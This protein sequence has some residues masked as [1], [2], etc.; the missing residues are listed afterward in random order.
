M[1]V[2]SGIRRLQFLQ[3]QLVGSLCHHPFA[4]F[5]TFED[6]HLVSVSTLEH[7]L[8]ALELF[9][10]Q[11]DVDNVLPFVFQYGLGRNHDDV[12]RRA[13]LESHVRLHTDAKAAIRV[14]NF[15]GDRQ[16][17]GLLVDSDPD[18]HY[19]ARE[20]GTGVSRSFEYRSSCIEDRRQILLKDWRL[21]PY[22]LEVYDFE[23][24][25]SGLNQLPDGLVDLGDFAPDGARQYVP[26][27]RCSPRRPRES[28][29]P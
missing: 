10:G 16:G 4:R 26:G 11:Q 15:E 9:T 17:P 14:A 6:G 20:F 19:P 1:T 5:E 2:F 13:G 23:D 18:I 25:F 12:P 22:R 7:N 3:L 28:E 24:R 27:G 21:D 29:L 8:A